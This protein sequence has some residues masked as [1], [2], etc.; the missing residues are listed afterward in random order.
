MSNE[1]DVNYFYH[2]NGDGTFTDI[3]GATGAD[4]PGTSI[5]GIFSDFNN[6]G[7]A[8]IYVLNLGANAL[9]QGD[10][11]GKFVDVTGRAKVANGGDG[12]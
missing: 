2:N 10:F 9:L 5:A 3:T 11:S 12:L 4:N 7:A 8:D 1:A 6:D